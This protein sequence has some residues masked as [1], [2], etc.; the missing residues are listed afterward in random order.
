MPETAQSKTDEKFIALALKRFKLAADAESKGRELSLDD[1]KFSVGEQWPAEIRTQLG[2]DA[3]M[4]VMDQIQQAVRQVSNEYR[5]QRPA[6]TVAPVGNDANVDTAEIIQG[7]IRHIEVRSDA[8]IAYDGAHEHMVRTGFG[9]WRFLTEYI[10]DD[11]NQEIV[12]EPIRNQFGVYWQP[13][14]SQGKATWCLLTSDIPV[15]EYDDKLE[16]DNTDAGRMNAKS[17]V[18]F[19]SEGDAQQG[20]ITKEY[21]RVAEYFIV[22][23]TAEK[24]KKTKRK[25]TWHKINALEE[26]DK[27]DLPGSSIPVFTVV[28]DDIEVDGKRYLAGLVRNAKDPQ[29]QYNY[30]VSKATKVIA[31]APLSP[32]VMEESQTEGHERMWEKANSTAYATLLYKGT[33]VNG[34]TLPAPQRQQVEPPIQAMA[35]MIRQAGLDLRASTGIYD[36]SLGQHKGDESGKAIQSLQKQGDVATLNYSDNMARTMR[37]AGNVGV[38]WIRHYYDAPRVQRIIKPDG[39]VSQVVIH[40]GADQA[41]QARQLADTQKQKIAKIYDIGVGD[42]DIVIDVGPNFKTKR[43]QAVS[44]QLELLKV[45]GPDIAKNLLDLVIP[46]MDIP[47]AKEIGARMKKMLP[48]QLQDQNDGDPEAKLQQMQQV[49]AHL[50]QQHQLLEKALRDATQVIQTKQVEQQ[51]K[52]EITKLQEDTKVLIAEINTKAQSE[53]E[54]QQ[55]YQE[56]WMEQHGAAHELGMQKDQQQHDAG[57]AAQSNQADQQS[58]AADQSHDVGMAAVNQAG[59]QQQDS[60]P[61]Q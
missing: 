28:G 55:M 14:V 34:A 56:F 11:G 57:M 19:S 53:R 39:S 42:Y 9:S 32:Y 45:V 13:G 37:R 44:T 22:K 1:L 5:Q 20:W 43:E 31:L 38:D 33:A 30:M 26:L 24:G 58:Q 61:Q 3:V 51:G 2:D 7:I 18:E 27:R 6:T 29:R 21:I 49:N 52:L 12:I 60:A 36:P 4:L 54:R 47:Q 41:G 40:K 46:N 17:L 50:A 10:D 8:E 25:V 15:E 23:E 59:E 48:P 35:M 16:T